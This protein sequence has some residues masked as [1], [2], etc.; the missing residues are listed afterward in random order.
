MLFNDDMLWMQIYH[1]SLRGTHSLLGYHEYHQIAVHEIDY[2][3]NANVV[4]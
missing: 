3:V 2:A 4:I 1:F